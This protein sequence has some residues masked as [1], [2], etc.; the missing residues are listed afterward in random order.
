MEK[1]L[2]KALALVLLE[3]RTDQWG[4]RIESPLKRAIEKWANDR[5]E[6]IASAIIKKL[7]VEEL[8]DKVSKRIVEDLSKSTSWSTNYD[9][10]NL[11]K[12][13]MEK[14]AQKLAEK[15]LEKLQNPELLK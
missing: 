6:D 10:E 11:K 12:I 1:E 7:G 9:S 13:V 14:V 2:Y 8:A 4:N 15:E 3:E 5:R